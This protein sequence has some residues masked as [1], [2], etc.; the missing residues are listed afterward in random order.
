[1]QSLW[2]WQ[3]GDG[4]DEVCICLQF[5]HHSDNVLSMHESLGSI[6]NF[7]SICTT[8]VSVWEGDVL[9]CVYVN[10]GMIRGQLMI[11]IWLDLDQGHRTCGHCIRFESKG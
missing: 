6:F 5:I 11:K 4:A 10:D 8:A 9:V 1:M 7:C 3:Q 2:D